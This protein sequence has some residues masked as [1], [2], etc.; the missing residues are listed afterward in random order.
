[1]L[2]RPVTLA[3]F[4]VPISIFIPMKGGLNFGQIAEI[5]QYCLR[6]KDGYII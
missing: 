4:E 1:M 2:L 5:L 3:T 6:I